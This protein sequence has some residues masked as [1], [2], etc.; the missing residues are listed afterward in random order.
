MLNKEEANTEKGKFELS[1]NAIRE[2]KIDRK[3]NMTVVEKIEKEVEIER[4]K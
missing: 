4:D 3:R 2:G 1:L